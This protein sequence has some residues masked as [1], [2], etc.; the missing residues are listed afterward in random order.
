[1]CCTSCNKVARSESTSALHVNSQASFDFDPSKEPYSPPQLLIR[2]RKRDSTSIPCLS[3]VKFA[4]PAYNRTKV[5]CSSQQNWML[6]TSF[7]PFHT[8]QGTFLYLEKGIPSMQAVGEVASHLSAP[9]CQKVLPQDTRLPR[10]L[11][12]P[13]QPLLYMLEAPCSQLRHAS[14]TSSLSCRKTCVSC[15]ITLAITLQ[16]WILDE[17]L[18]M[19]KGTLT[20]PFTNVNKARKKPDWVS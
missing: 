3:L 2:K 9:S 5:L 17:W 8:P 11:L 12:S 1:M 6:K 19:F 18:K 14:T 4:C 16:P 10:K 7:C 13:H 15:R 20:S